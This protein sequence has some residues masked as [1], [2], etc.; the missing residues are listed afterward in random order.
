MSASE[1]TITPT[2]MFINVITGEYPKYLADVRKDNPTKSFAENPSED[3]MALMGYAVVHPTDLPIGEV[4]REGS[5]ILKNGKWEQVWNARDFT[6][7]E[8]IDNFPNIKND[9]LAL[10]RR[11][12]FNSLERGYLYTFPDN[13]KGHIQ[14][15]S[16][17]RANLSG[18]RLKAMSAKQTG[19]TATFGFR[20]YENI[21][22]MGLS[23][24]EIIVLSDIAFEKY[25][26]ILGICWNLKDATESALNYEQLPAIPDNLDAFGV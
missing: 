20:T 13:S 23:A 24:D 8:R 10:I 1:T 16:G 21:T 2:T 15:R 12:Q 25:M 18:L 14:L 26:L 6:V 11:L 5:P 22:K 4:V 7:Q 9:H 3:T 19:V 17:D